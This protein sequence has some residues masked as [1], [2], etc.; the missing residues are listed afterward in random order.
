MALG[1]AVATKVGNEFKSGSIDP[2]EID[3]APTRLAEKMFSLSI[4]MTR[5]A[6]ERETGLTDRDSTDYD[7][8]WGMYRFKNAPMQAPQTKSIA[9]A[10]TGQ[11]TYADTVG[12]V[13]IPDKRSKKDTDLKYLDVTSNEKFQKL[14]NR[15]HAPN[16]EDRKS[17]V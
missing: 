11:V 10:R 4:A 15:R 2:V 14:Q 13:Y 6:F 9:F 12:W 1:T 8:K 17:V 3:P 7:K 5:A 16:T